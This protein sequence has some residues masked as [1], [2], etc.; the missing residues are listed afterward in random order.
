MGNKRLIFAIIIVILLIAGLIGGYLY[1]QNSREQASILQEELTNIV[2][3]NL[4]ENDIDMTIKTTGKYGVVE[5][6]IKNYLNDVKNTYNSVENYCNDD[7][8]S[9]I[10]STENI[11][12][13]D[14]NLS[15]VKQKVE[16]YSTK[17]D[18]YKEEI[19]LIDDESNI[20]KAI[21]NKNLSDYYDNIYKNVMLSD[22]MKQNLESIKT[23][24]E[25][26][27]EEA[28]TKLDGLNN[29]VD[30]LEENTKYWEISDGKIQFTNVNKLAEYYNLLN[31]ED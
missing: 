25:E 10:L 17:L 3:M 9:Q 29:T 1:L 31:E 20:T 8:L 4:S 13:D 30:F 24:A 18:E 6:T 23:K 5:E 22:A 7:E 14:E 28:W 11:E 15:V 12:A 19:N 26:A 2:E 27:Q 21:E 16:E